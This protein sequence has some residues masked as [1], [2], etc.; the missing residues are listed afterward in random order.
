METI[1]PKTVQDIKD[2]FKTFGV[3]TTRIDGLEA[4]FVTMPDEFTITGITAREVTI[5]GQT[6]VVPEFE[7][8]SNKVK[9]TIPIG[10]LFASYVGT[11]KASKITKK[12]SKYEGKYLVSNNKRVNS[13]AEGL[14]EAEFILAVMGKKF[15]AQPAAD[16]QVYSGFVAKDGANVL[17]FHDSEEAAIAA[18]APKSYRRVE[19]Q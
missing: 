18:I 10:Q 9:S 5:T 11:P 7:V 1:K 13:F 4:K 8:L 19:I 2:A 17:T 6:R 14:S 12:G 15:K 16:F 3:S